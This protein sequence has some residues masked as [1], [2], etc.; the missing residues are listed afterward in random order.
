MTDIH[1]VSEL[2]NTISHADD[3]C[4]I[5]R[6]NGNA[7]QSLIRTTSYNY[8]TLCLKKTSFQMN[9]P[10]YYLVFHREIITIINARLISMSDRNKS[11]YSKQ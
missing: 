7:R 9:K 10:Y 6:F 5:M 2:F 8:P 1:N 3:T 4:R 11:T